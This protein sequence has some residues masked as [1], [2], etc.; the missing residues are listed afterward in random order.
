MR[1]LQL[2]LLSLM[3]GVTQ[4]AMAD[5]VV[6]WG[7][8]MLT[9]SV[10]EGPTLKQNLES[11]R[12]DLLVFDH[13]VG[14]VST[15]WLLERS[16]EE[17]QNNYYCRYVILASTNDPR[18]GET[19]PKQS[20]KRLR[21]I[22]AKARNHANGEILLTPLPIGFGNPDND[23]VREVGNELIRL[24]GASVTYNV[25]DARDIFISPGWAWYNIDGVHLNSDGRKL[26]AKFLAENL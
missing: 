11:L 14:G 21:S 19:D 4:P 24:N 1:F 23:F 5:C 25:L 2:I 17:M 12:P 13:A 16:K 6:F 3:L 20:A 26:L 9:A 22:A 8:S 10:D 7:D 15:E 18:L